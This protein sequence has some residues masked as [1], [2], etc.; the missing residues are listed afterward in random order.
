MDRVMFR[1]RQNFSRWIVIGLVLAIAVLSDGFF[2][3]AQ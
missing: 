1:K 2:S 3:G